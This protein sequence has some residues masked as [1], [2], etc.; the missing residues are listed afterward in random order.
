MWE[1]MIRPFQHRVAPLLGEIRRLTLATEEQDG[2]VE[3]V[4]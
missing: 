1:V 3:D 4:E 2:M